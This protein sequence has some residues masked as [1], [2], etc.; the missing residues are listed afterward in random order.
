[1]VVRRAV[2]LVVGLMVLQA[3]SA[4]AAPDMVKAGMCS[5]GA[6][7]RL[8]VTDTGDWIKVRFEVHRSPAGHEWRIQFRY[9]EHNIIPIVTDLFFHGTRVASDGG[10]FVVQVR[11]LDWERLRAGLVGKAVDGQTGQV[12]KVRTWYRD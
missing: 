2:V 8:E 11:H 7:W 4:S 5:D 9:L 3:T 1:M 6:R 10:V 12:C